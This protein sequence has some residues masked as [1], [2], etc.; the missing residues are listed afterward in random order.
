[1]TRL[2]SKPPWFELVLAYLSIPTAAPLLHYLAFCV[3]S[4]SLLSHPH[5][6]YLWQWE[7]PQ[8]G[9]CLLWLFTVWLSAWLSGFLC[10]SCLPYRC[11]RWAKCLLKL[12]RLA[13][14]KYSISGL[15]ETW[16]K[17]GFLLI[18][19]LNLLMSAYILFF[20]KWAKVHKT[21]SPVSY[22]IAWNDLALFFLA[23]GLSTKTSPKTTS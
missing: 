17:Y 5:S 4:L 15:K 7:V 11:S 2:F 18:I 19:L 10:L 22:S 21:N 1:M 20:E 23:C 14:F 6:R 8:S 9:Q 16:K 3:L 13:P 12:S